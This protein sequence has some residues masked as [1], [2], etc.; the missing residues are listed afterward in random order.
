MQFF[1]CKCYFKVILLQRNDF[2]LNVEVMMA[3]WVHFIK[4]SV[5]IV[6]KNSLITDWVKDNNLVT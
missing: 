3:V 2:S 1:D 6:I 4:A 5:Q